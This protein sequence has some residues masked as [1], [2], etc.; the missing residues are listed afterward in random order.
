[1]STSPLPLDPVHAAWRAERFTLNDEITNAASQTSV[2]T[3]ALFSTGGV[4]ASYING[5]PL[6]GLDKVAASYPY[7]GD[8]YSVAVIDTGIDYT[9]PALGGGW[10]KR[11][12][13]GWDFVNNDQDPM[14]DNGHGTHV[15]GIIGS[16]DATY[17]GVAPHVRF[18][19]LKVL[20]ASGSGSFGAVED[21]LQWVVD[22]R[23]QFN[24]VAIN[25]SLGSGNYTSNPYTFLDPEFATLTQQGV[26]IS[27]ASGNSYYSFGSQQGLS[28]PAIDPYAVSVGAVWA[29][30]FGPISWQ[31]GAKDFS[32]AA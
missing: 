15:A 19:A 5:G 22:H 29:G 9:H 4:N 6:I 30:N 14:D 7:P 31:S 27:V 11:V 25:L 17:T 24:I 32:T 20:D 18:V 2:A 28:Y 13:A 1:L 3:G 8:G 21:A 10:G 26:F 12:I 23:A 16:S